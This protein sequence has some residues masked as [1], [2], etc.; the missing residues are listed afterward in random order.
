[1]HLVCGVIGSFL[2]GVAFGPV[3]LCVVDI[4]LKR[5]FQAG[6]RFV[7]AATLAEV[8]HSSIAIMFGKLI[9]NKLEE[10]PELQWLVIAFFLILGFYFIIKKDKPIVE[11]ENSRKASNFLK[12][13]VVAI[14][15]PQAIPYWIFA[16][17]YLK[18]SNYIDLKS[19]HMFVFLVGVYI[20]KFIILGL[21]SYLSDYIKKHLTNLNDYISKTI[22]LFL[23]IIGIVQIVKYLY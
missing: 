5:S 22:G 2:S 4:T 8:I 3:N 20:G 11:H 1:M 21:Y 15:N 6:M 12:G 9:S 16:L 13:F 23:I 7:A 17:A 10:I 14:F 19:W 18:S